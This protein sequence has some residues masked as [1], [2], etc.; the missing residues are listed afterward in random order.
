MLQLGL[1][2][3]EVLLKLT[4]QQLGKMDYDRSAGLGKM[5]GLITCCLYPRYYIL[6]RTWK[7]WSYALD[8]T[9]GLKIH[10]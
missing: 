5:E 4:L 8:F 9:D 7:T 3:E 1:R 10:L 6:Y 2:I